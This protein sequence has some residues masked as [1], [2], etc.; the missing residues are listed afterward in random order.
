MSTK[1]VL[2]ECRLYVTLA[3]TGILTTDEFLGWWILWVI[4]CARSLITVWIGS[5][6]VNTSGTLS[7]W[8]TGF[9]SFVGKMGL[10][11]IFPM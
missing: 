6:R 3:V 9:M 5:G 11:C 1:R 2:T 7:R 4:S 10:A 8:E